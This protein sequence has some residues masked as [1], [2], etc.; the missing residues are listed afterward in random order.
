MKRLEKIARKIAELENRCQMGDDE[1]HC[2]EEMLHLI[3]K[4]KPEEL[5]FIDEYI[6]RNNLLKDFSIFVFGILFKNEH[7]DLLF[8]WL[9]QQPFCGRDPGHTAQ[10]HLNLHPRSGA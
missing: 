4:L 5:L 8:L 9:R 10:R 7:H 1:P 6:F 2:I 3:R